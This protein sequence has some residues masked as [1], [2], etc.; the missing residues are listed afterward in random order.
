VQG[1]P[2]SITQTQKSKNLKMHFVKKT[3]SLQKFKNYRS[4]CKT[5]RKKTKQLVIFK[6]KKHQTPKTPK[7]P[8]RHLVA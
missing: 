6:N 1:I 2:K 7:V 4:F 8:T 5:M 3:C